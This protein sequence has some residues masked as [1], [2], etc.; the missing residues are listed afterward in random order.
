MA[1]DC[2]V[3]AEQTCCVYHSEH[4][5]PRR[6]ADIPMPVTGREVAEGMARIL[7]Q[8]LHTA[9]GVRRKQDARTN[10]QTQ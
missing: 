9:D 2:G 3:G 8:P 10:P 1:G 7:L 4:A 6:I 5:L